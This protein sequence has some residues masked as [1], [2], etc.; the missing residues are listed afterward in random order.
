MPEVLDLSYK[1]Y[2]FSFNKTKKPSKN[3]LNIEKIVKIYQFKRQIA[4]DYGKSLP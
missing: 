3:I 4:M 1:H 2:T